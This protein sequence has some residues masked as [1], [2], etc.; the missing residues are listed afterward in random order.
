MVRAFRDESGVTYY[1]GRV[2][3]STTAVFLDTDWLN[4]NGMRRAWRQSTI[5]NRKTFWYRVPV[6]AVDTQIQHDTS[7]LSCTFT[8]VKLAFA[9]MGLSKKLAKLSQAGNFYANPFCQVS[10]AV[11]RVKGFK[12]KIIRNSSASFN[13]LRDVQRKRLYLIQIR[14][15]NTHTGNTDN[16]HAI[17]IFDNL[18]FDV[19]IQDPLPLTR[20]S[21][22]RCCLGD[23]SW[24]YD[25]SVRVAMFIPTERISR[26][27]EKRCLRKI[28]VAAL[29][30]S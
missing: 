19:N 3:G 26:C 7:L 14:A 4:E 30:E 11:Q 1:Q 28:P 12:C 15:K 5:L 18:I 23:D 10:K 29:Q 16:F 22:N 8:S 6:Q 24:V 17:S 27:I 20:D 9:Y 2:Q 25:A 21:L 13:P